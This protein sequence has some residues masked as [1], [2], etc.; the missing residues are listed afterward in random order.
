MPRREEAG[1]RCQA[2]LLMSRVGGRTS[3]SQVKSVSPLEGSPAAT[4]AASG[5]QIGS[6]RH[7][8]MPGEWCSNL[9]DEVPRRLG[10]R[11]RVPV[12]YKSNTKGQ[13]HALVTGTKSHWPRLQGCQ[14]RQSRP[15]PAAERQY[16]REPDSELADMEPV[17]LARSSHQRVGSLFFRANEPSAKNSSPIRPDS[18]TGNRNAGQTP[19]Q[20]SPS[21]N[22][23]A[24]PS[25]RE[26]WLSHPT[27]R[28]S[29][30]SLLHPGRPRPTKE[31]SFRKTRASKLWN[32][33]SRA[34]HRAI[35][36]TVR[37]QNRF[38]GLA[39]SWPNFRFLARGNLCG[40]ARSEKDARR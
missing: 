34:T 17:S 40:V 1:S 10:L 8:I 25:S 26:V 35:P 37:N 20:L 2:G 33:S 21:W 29:S 6:V 28:G 18:A 32:D 3:L 5:S 9:T 19:T 38:F 31:A 4:H 12:G 11:G 23:D 15:L 13:P 27:R 7:A 30:P 39:L 36:G 16:R 24:I 14:Q 22:S